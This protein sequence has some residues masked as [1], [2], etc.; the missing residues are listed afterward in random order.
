MAALDGTALLAISSA[1]GELT[2]EQATASLAITA[3]A[4]SS[5]LGGA[6]AALALT[7]SGALSTDI[8]LVATT[9]PLAVAITGDL[10]LDKHTALLEI[11]AT[12]T[13]SVERG[14]AALAIT[15]S[16]AL[17]TGIV[18]GTL[19]PAT[20]SIM[21]V[22]S[23]LQT[24]IPL[25]GTATL[26][27][28]VLAHLVSAD[29]PKRFSL[30]ASLTIPATMWDA[31][32][33]TAEPFI[34]AHRDDRLSLY[35][36]LKDS[37]GNEY[38]VS[39]IIDGWIDE[40]HLIVDKNSML[41]RLNGRDAG[42]E[43]LDR[44]VRIQYIRDAALGA[45]QQGG[46][47]SFFIPT[48]DGN[49]MPTFNNFTCQPLGRTIQLDVSTN[50]RLALELSL[51]PV[52]P[53]TTRQIGKFTAAGIAAAIVSG[54]GLGL[55]WLVPDY[56][57]YGDFM[58]TGRII[59]ILNQLIEPFVQVEPFR[60]DI[61]VVGKTVVIQA[62][63]PFPTADYTYTIRDSRISNIEVFKRQG[64]VFGLA[65]I[66]GAKQLQHCTPPPS[67]S[68]G[69]TLGETITYDPNGA[70]TGRVTTRIETRS[71]DNAMTFQERYTYGLNEDGNLVIQSIE[72]TVYNWEGLRLDPQ[73][74]ALLN[75]P[76][77][78]GS[79][80]LTSARN[81]ET[82]LL[83][84]SIAETTSNSYDGN[85]FQTGSSVTRS[86]KNPDTG[87]MRVTY[88]EFKTF[89]QGGG[90]TM[91]TTTILAGDPLTLQSSGSEISGGRPFGGPGSPAVAR[92]VPNGAQY[93]I[94]K[95]V[96]ESP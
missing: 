4:D 14:S 19:R 76:V 16:G 84:L 31:D 15:A 65:T 32:Y 71:G 6:S 50:P 41:S 78:L 42:A 81:P 20:C 95:M 94:R 72:N 53:G 12:G 46:Q 51:G 70:Q 75:R 27:L 3:S 91:R 13:L 43:L 22:A 8:R 17:T 54:T 63:N 7:A 73:T 38:K 62:R 82:G 34:H 88:Q 5:L 89:A 11:L 33:P 39:G 86:E 48:L 57:L 28:T 79:S 37:L 29:S 92:D 21:A 52:P 45:F 56:P 18:L 77:Q 10:T 26:S 30:N 1:S 23:T 96:S 93:F 66:T 64:P 59:D 49:G 55:S 40:Y 87:G 69:G 36:G 9:A 47:Q 90:G 2:L 24:A 25:V 85:K 67:G 35:L 68:G 44:T 74:G 83:S 58:A 61:R 80:M 60:A